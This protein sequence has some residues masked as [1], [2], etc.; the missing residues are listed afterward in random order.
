[1]A[2]I[3]TTVDDSVKQRADKVFE[4]AGLTTPMAV[5]VMVTQVA[6]EGRS[7]FDGLFSRGT[8]VELAEDVKRDMII[9]EAQEYGIIPDD[10]LP[11]PLSI[12]SDVLAS[13]GIK[14]A[15]VGQE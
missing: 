14:P 11:D 2:L 9:A 3:Q 6:N 4:R 15:E 1:M 8:A 10:S 7:P 12:P 13:L 5:R